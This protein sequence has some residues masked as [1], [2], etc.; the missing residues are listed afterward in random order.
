MECKDT[1]GFIANRIG[2]YW[3]QCAVVEAMRAGLSVEQADAALGPAVGIPKTG[4]FGLVD[5]VG[6]DLMPHVVASMDS[7][8]PP[9]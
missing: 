3:L 4:V 9:G 5:L 8:L 7:L 6:I 1:P 2:V